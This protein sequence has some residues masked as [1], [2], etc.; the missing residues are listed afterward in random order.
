MKHQTQSRIYQVA[1]AAH[2]ETIEKFEVGDVVWLNRQHPPSSRVLRLAV[3]QA[4]KAYSGRMLDAALVYARFGIP[5]FPVS[6]NT[7]RPIPPR[8]PDP[9]GKFKDGI[10]GTGGVYKA[11]TD[12]KQIYEWWDGHEWLIAMPMGE[13]SGVWCLDVDTAEDHVDGTSGWAGLI[14]QHEPF[15]TREHRSATGGPHVIFN[16][17]AEQPIRCSAGALPSGMEVKGQG[18]YI[19]VPPSQRKGRS[20]S[21]YRDIDPNDAPQ[22]LVDLILQGRVDTGKDGDEHRPFDGKAEVGE[23]ELAEIMSFIPNDETVDGEEWITYK[24]RIFAASGGSD[25][26]FKIFDEW[27][28][29]WPRQFDSKKKMVVGYSAAETRRH[30]ELTKGSPPNQTGIGK[31]RKIAREHGWS[32]RLYP[33]T[34]TYPDE[35]DYISPAKRTKIEQETWDFL[36]SLIDPK[37]S[38]LIEWQFICEWIERNTE[39]CRLKIHIDS[40][41][42]HNETVP[43]DVR[44][45]WEKW[46]KAT[47]ENAIQGAL[48]LWKFLGLAVCL[49]PRCSKTTKSSVR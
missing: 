32:P 18:G 49:R 31:L 6:V 21:V 30:W 27:S 28:Q 1:D 29:R 23:D 4:I 33:H 14:A 39:A 44:Y 42:R 8:D 41:E 34:P 12:P 15:E 17:N 25:W 22:W 24:L 26:G 38:P 35:G 36:D 16:W 19:V 3:K 5:I 46:G 37:H 10:P 47:L 11:T 43:P 48:H 9:T 2:A 13:A 7:K 20:Y 40:L 45:A